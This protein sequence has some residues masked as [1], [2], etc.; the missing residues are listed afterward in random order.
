MNVEALPDA[1]LHEILFHL[2]LIDRTEFARGNRGLAGRLMKDVREVFFWNPKKRLM[3]PSLLFSFALTLINNP[4]LQLNIDLCSFEQGNGPIFTL[5]FSRIKVFRCSMKHLSLLP[6]DKVKHIRELRVNLELKEREQLTD[7]A[8]S[9]QRRDM[10]VDQLTIYCLRSNIDQLPMFYGINS[11]FINSST[12]LTCSALNL[13]RYSNLR[14]LKLISCVLVDDVSLFC[15]IYDLHLENCSGV[16]DIACL[17]QNHVI[18]IIKCNNINDY[19]NSFKFS[20]K[21]RIQCDSSTRITGSMQIYNLQKVKKLDLNGHPFI[22]D[23]RQLPATLAELILRRIP[24][25]FC[26][27][28]NNLRE[29]LLSCCDKV[30]SLCN[31]EKIKNVTLEGLDI[32]TL[33]GLGYGNKLVFISQCPFIQ[34]FHVLKE[35]ECLAVRDYPLVTTA[36]LP[37]INIQEVTHFYTTFPNLSIFK[38]AQSLTVVTV[39][40][41]QFF[42]DNKN[43]DKILSCLELLNVVLPLPALE[44]VKIKPFNFQSYIRFDGRFQALLSQYDFICDFCGDE[45]VLLKGNHTREIK[46]RRISQRFFDLLMKIYP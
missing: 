43:H 38:T 24:S 45:L 35:I 46:K 5:P 37:L 17:N 41:T 20:T 22:V 10:T 9:L 36:R 28:A 26:L 34:D 4:L 15:D 3:D 42:H 2:P 7:F 1:L 12:S 30:L 14:S 21:I 18:S 27:P 31:M 29:I 23:D 11:L 6:Q 39:D 19:S 25:A 16:T 32:T 13:H 33:R 40:L 8:E 44:K